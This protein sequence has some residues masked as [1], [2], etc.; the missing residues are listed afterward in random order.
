MS[1]RWKEDTSQRAHGYV[2][3]AAVLMKVPADLLS[4]HAI[5]R[6]ASTTLAR[7]TTGNVVGNGISVDTLFRK[8]VLPELPFWASRSCMPAL[9][10]Y[11]TTRAWCT[12]TTGYS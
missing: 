4:R 12:C 6:D 11:I 1:S 2:R 3:R 8:R 5:A 7:P 10:E 9:L